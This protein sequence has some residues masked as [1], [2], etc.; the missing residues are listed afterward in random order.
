MD[1][2]LRISVWNANGLIHHIQELKHF[3]SHHNIDVMLISET[4]FTNK[5]YLNIPNYT[6]YH[7]MHPDGSAD[8]GSAIIIKTKIKHYEVDKFQQE[9]IQ[10]TNCI[11]E[12]WTG[13]ITISA[14]YGPS[15]HNIKEEL[16]VDFFK[17]LGKR[18]LAA[19]DFNAYPMGFKIN[20]SQRT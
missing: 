17:T 14:I 19:G 11:I 10:A 13:E 6:I 12:D 20:S 9:H 5:N 4:H 18:F 7:T 1:Q 2:T 16:Y 3:L 8:G 15:K